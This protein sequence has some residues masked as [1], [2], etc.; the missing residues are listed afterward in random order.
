[1]SISL[2]VTEEKIMKDYVFHIFV[3]TLLDYNI[4][5]TPERY[6]LQK[7]VAGC[8]GLRSFTILAEE[9]L[10]QHAAQLNHVDL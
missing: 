8:T 5:I 10:I 1:M 4:G 7:N 9:Q 2:L 3:L 6:I